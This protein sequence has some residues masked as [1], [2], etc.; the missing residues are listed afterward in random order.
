M[1]VHSDAWRRRRAANDERFLRVI[2]QLRQ[3]IANLE[4]VMGEDGHRLRPSEYAMSVA[5]AMECV[6]RAAS[7]LH[8]DP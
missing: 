1:P 6:D 2:A 4:G 7:I 3:A 8:S 5:D